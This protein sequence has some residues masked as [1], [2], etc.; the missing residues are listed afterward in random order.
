[1]ISEPIC[2]IGVD[3]GGTKTQAVLTNE[4]GSP[5]A[6]GMGGCGNPTRVS[7]VQLRRSYQQAIGETLAGV[8]VAVRDAVKAICL[9]VAGA[10]GRDDVIRDAV[11]DLGLNAEI[12]IDGDVQI[13]FAAAIREWHGVIVIAGTGANAYG[14]GLDGRTATAS[15]RG[16]LIGDEGSGYDIGRAG[17]AAA[18]RADDGRGP[19]TGLL[20]RMLNFFEISRAEDVV[21]PIYDPGGKAY[22]SRFAPTVVEAAK[23]DDIVAQGILNYAGRELGLNV[24]AVARRTGLTDEPFEVGLVGGVFKAGELVVASLRTTVLAVAPRAEIFI[25]PNA[26]ALGAARLALATLDIHIPPPHPLNHSQFTI[27]H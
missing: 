18:L 23:A 1:M 17:I 4:G 11:A 20:P 14:V 2:V 12:I 9:G 24:L 21:Q 3:A 15:G 25:S 10:S 19:S 7:A 16:Y 13:A 22:I 8:D 5:L 6:W 26:P 27:H